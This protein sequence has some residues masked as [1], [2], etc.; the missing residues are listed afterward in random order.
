MVSQ[1]GHF[2]G[3]GCAQATNSGTIT[4]PE[5]SGFLRLILSGPLSP[6]IFPLPRKEEGRGKRWHQR[7]SGNL[8]T[9]WFGKSPSIGQPAQGRSWEPGGKAGWS[10]GRSNSLIQGYSQT[11]ISLVP[12]QYKAKNKPMFSTHYLTLEKVKI[13]RKFPLPGPPKTDTLPPP[14]SRPRPPRSSP[15]P[16]AVPWRTL[17]GMLEYTD[18]LGTPGTSE[19]ETSS[20]QRLPEKARSACTRS[21]ADSAGHVSGRREGARGHVGS[22]GRPRRVEPRPPHPQQLQAQVWIRGKQS[23]LMGE[24]PWDP[25][26]GSFCRPGPPPGAQVLT[27]CQPRRRGHPHL[28]PPLAEQPVASGGRA[29]GGPTLCGQCA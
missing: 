4:R 20:S 12:L 24:S 7:K 13:N 1:L 15:F 22:R 6:S 21:H 10:S 23:P 19:A 28:A 14:S 26:V 9:C 18:R 17:S 3:A 8:H 5:R 11:K 27:A 2:P 16:M 25:F 29:A